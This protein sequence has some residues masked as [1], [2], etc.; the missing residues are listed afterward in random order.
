MEAKRHIIMFYKPEIRKAILAKRKHMDPTAII[1]AANQS[2]TRLLRLSQFIDSRRIGHYLADDGE[3]DPAPIIRIAEMQQ[4]QFYLPVIDPSDNKVMS[5]YLHNKNEPLTKNR[6]GIKEPITEGKHPIE[7]HELDIVFVPLV[8]FDKHC[9]RIGRGAGYYDKTF[10]F[11]NEMTAG[12]RPLLIGLAYEFQKV[13][14][15][16]PAEWDVPLDMVITEKETYKR[17]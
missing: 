2:A 9:N 1:Q 10:A 4:K 14:E 12:K 3:F 6:Y 16:V 7:L 8:G 13:Y 11:V 5:F 15:I 17:Y